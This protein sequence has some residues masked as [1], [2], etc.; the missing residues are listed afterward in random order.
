MPVT[1]RGQAD[2]KLLLIKSVLD[3]YERQHA[4]INAVIYRQNSISIRI[5]V[6]D[7]AF[8][9]LEKSDRHARI[10][11]LLEKLP[12]DVQSDISMVVLLAPEE[13]RSSLA[14]L[15]FENPSPSLIK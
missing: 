13:E 11:N 5:K 7:P 14:N 9:G 8:A 12:E 4:A 6:V 1:I 2:D 15:E 3:E 10:W